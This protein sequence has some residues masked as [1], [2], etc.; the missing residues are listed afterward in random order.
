VHRIHEIVDLVGAHVSAAEG[1]EAEDD[2]EK[3]LA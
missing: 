1:R 3:H 2:A